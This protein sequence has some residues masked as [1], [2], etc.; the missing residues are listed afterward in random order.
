MFHSLQALM[1]GMGGGE[2]SPKLPPKDFLGRE[3]NE[4]MILLSILCQNP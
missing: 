3:K 2:A 1:G 4:D